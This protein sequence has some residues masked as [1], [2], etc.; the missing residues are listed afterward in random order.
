[1]LSLPKEDLLQ[2]FILHA[3]AAALLENIQFLS[4]GDS[5]IIVR[6]YMLL[7]SQATSACVRKDKAARENKAP[8]CFGECNF[9]GIICSAEPD[10]PQNTGCTEQLP[11]RRRPRGLFLCTGPVHSAVIFH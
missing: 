1:M 5:I 10:Q 8:A 9:K 2:N 4:Q 11:E 7:L 3:R 6:I